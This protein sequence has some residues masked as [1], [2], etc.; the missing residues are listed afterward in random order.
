MPAHSVKKIV[1][2]IQRCIQECWQ[3]QAS[4]DEEEPDF[5]TLDSQIQAYQDIHTHITGEEFDGELSPDDGGETEVDE[6]EKVVL[7][8]ESTDDDDDDDTDETEE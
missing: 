2:Y 8:S 7:E 5:K 3:A 1:A 6:T 4:L